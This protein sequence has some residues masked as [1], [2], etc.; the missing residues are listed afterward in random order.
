VIHFL[1][2]MHGTSTILRAIAIAN[3]SSLPKSAPPSG[4]SSRFR[5]TFTALRYTNYRLW[6]VGQLVSLFGTWMQITAIGFLIFDLTHSPIYLGYAGFAT[7]IR[8]GCSRC[9]AA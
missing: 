1:R 8:A 3:N 5:N 2:T 7:G 4:G 9:M 6:F